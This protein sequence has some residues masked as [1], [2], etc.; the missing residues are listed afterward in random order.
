MERWL[1][2]PLEGRVVLLSLLLLLRCTFA[3]CDGCALGR[4]RRVAGRGLHTS[5]LRLRV[6][7]RYTVG[8]DRG[9][10]P[11][12]SCLTC[13]PVETCLGMH[14]CF[15]CYATSQSGNDMRVRG[16]R[17]S[18]QDE[19]GKKRVKCCTNKRNVESAQ[20]TAVYLLR[21]LWVEGIRG[22]PYDVT[23]RGR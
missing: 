2:G 17:R 8:D 9:E 5:K 6:E 23:V 11:W 20:R 14:G 16:M 1:A 3:D 22:Q 18:V 10:G 13:W 19:E 7:G 4:G 12:C 21:P 15:T